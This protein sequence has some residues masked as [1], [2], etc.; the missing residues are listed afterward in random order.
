[1]RNDMSFFNET[2]DEWIDNLQ[3]DLC[4]SKSLNNFSDFDNEWKLSSDDDD[5]D[6]DDRDI[7]GS[8]CSESIND[9][10]YEKKGNISKNKKK[11]YGFDIDVAPD[12]TETNTLFSYERK[13]LFYV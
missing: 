2:E 9:C 4:F 12:I 10:D 6:D 7:E 5:D 1:M 11:K 8:D 13:G 3:C